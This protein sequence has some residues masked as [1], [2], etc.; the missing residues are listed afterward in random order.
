[1]KYDA[2]ILQSDGFLNL[3]KIESVVSLGTDAYYKPIPLARYEYAKPGKASSEIKG[4]I[5]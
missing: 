2:S 1:V 3:H 5:P 4:F